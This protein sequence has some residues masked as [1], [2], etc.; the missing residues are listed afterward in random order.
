VDRQGA[1]ATRFDIWLSRLR[2]LDRSLLM[3]FRNTFRR[4]ARFLLSVGLLAT[5]GAIFIGGLNTLAGNPV[6]TSHV[7]G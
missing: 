5:A 6:D 2:G 7:G 4:R 1:T 3:A